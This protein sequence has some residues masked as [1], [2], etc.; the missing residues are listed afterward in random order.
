MVPVGFT[1]QPEEKFLELLGSVIRSADY[2][3]LAPETT[4]R[5][6]ADGELVPNG[7]HRRFAALAG[8]RPCVAHGV[9]MSLGSGAASDAAR[10]RRWLTR[11]RDDQR[12]FGFRW[13][14]EHLGATALAGASVTLP[15][16]VP[17]T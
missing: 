10:Q 14:T 6:R 8:S 15:V 1:L 16:P 2:L 12:V 5:E 11:L 7:F 3:E 4:W 9:G 17:M 13:Y